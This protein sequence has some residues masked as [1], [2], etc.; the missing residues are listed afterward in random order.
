MFMLRLG[1]RNGFPWRWISW[2]RAIPLI[3]ARASAAAH[4]CHRPAGRIQPMRGA[5]G[6]WLMT[7]GTG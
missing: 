1:R 7:G 3:L 4:N 5:R 2:I 6:N